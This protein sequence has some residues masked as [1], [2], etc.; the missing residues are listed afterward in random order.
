MS[1]EQNSVS[2]FEVIETEDGWNAITT[3]SRVG[4]EVWAR[5]ANLTYRYDSRFRYNFRPRGLA[6]LVLI[7]EW[8]N[9][10]VSH[11]QVDEGDDAPVSV[12]E[13]GESSITLGWD[14]TWTTGRKVRIQIF[15]AEYPNEGTAYIRFNTGTGKPSTFLNEIFTSVKAEAEN[16]VIPAE[17]A[18]QIR[19]DLAFAFGG[20]SQFGTEDVIK[21][22]CGHVRNGTLLRRDKSVS[23]AVIEAALLQ[24]EERWADQPTPTSE[25]WLA[26]HLEGDRIVGDCWEAQRGNQGARGYGMPKGVVRAPAIVD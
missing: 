15:P 1:I 23:M 24:E 11:A 13:E 22:V 16:L 14:G 9:L 3:S 8:A 2:S 25:E 19:G 17:M 18:K 20:Y 7:K 21:A 4:A 6:S 12:L 10:V 26:I 5:L